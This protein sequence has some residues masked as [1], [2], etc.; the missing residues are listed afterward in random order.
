MSHYRGLRSVPLDDVEL[1][2]PD[3]LTMRPRISGLAD[4]T[5]FTQEP[6]RLIGAL[7]DDLDAGS[8]RELMER[9][10]R[11]QDR[12]RLLR[13][14]AVQALGGAALAH[15]VLSFVPKQIHEMGASENDLPLPQTRSEAPC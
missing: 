2:W 11:R 14:P 13:T 3:E 1:P 4:L 7:A 12:D 5:E 9:D 8:I 15:T 10:Q 6:L